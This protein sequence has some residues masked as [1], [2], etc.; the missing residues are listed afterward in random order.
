[1]KINKIFFIIII[2]LLI[3]NFINPE[4]SKFYTS[5]GGVDYK[6]LPLLFPFQA[7]NC[8]DQWGIENTKKRQFFLP[9]NVVE[10]GIINNYIIGKCDEFKVIDKKTPERYFIF[11]ISEKKPIYFESKA[12]FE[13]K[14][15]KLG[16][17][18]YK[19]DDIND[20]YKTFAEKG[21]C[22]WFPDSE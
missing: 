3:L 15:K 12:D 9:P 10:L 5:T 14:L 4:D 21:R 1:M 18:K 19:L 11:N 22:Y 2:H 13:K 7:F 6:R 20:L 8:Y 17:E 16:I